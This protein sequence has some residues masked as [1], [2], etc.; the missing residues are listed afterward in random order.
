MKAQGED[1]EIS[2]HYHSLYA[3]SYD[4]ENAGAHDQHQAMEHIL[5][6]GHHL[7]RKGGR[8][9]MPFDWVTVHWKSYLGDMGGDLMEDSKNYMKGHPMVFQLGHF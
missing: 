9:C 2:Q 3:R 1:N 4:H 7:N 8:N 5:V 6:E